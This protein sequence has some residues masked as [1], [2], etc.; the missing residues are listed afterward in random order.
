MEYK[1]YEGRNYAQLSTHFSARE[2]RCRHCGQVMVDLALVN[3]L[4][5]IRMILNVGIDV[6]VQFTIISGYRCPVSNASE[7]VKGV[8]ASQHLIGTACDGYS[9]QRSIID[10]Y[11]AA[12]LVAEFVNGGIGLYPGKIPT[13]HLDVRK[14]IARWARI[15]GKYVEI[16]QAF[17]LIWYPGATEA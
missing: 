16:A 9:P 10:V 8:K 1:N 17:P 4:E 14:S 6:D 2:F 5:K 13:I 15:K 12:L 11:H 7:D 3:G